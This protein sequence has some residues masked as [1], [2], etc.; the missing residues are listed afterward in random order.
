[1]AW[2]PDEHFEALIQKAIDFLQNVRIARHTVYREYAI[3][4]LQGNWG[5]YRI[6]IS[7]VHRGDKTVKYSYYLL[8]Q[9]NGLVIG[10]DNSADN[11]VLRLR[12]G[13]NWMSHLHEELPHQHTP[14][15]DIRLTEW[16]DFDGF[17]A[18]VE[19][20]L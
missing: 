17:I 3:L 1:M 11:L 20:N 12:Y 6:I 15:G 19:N 14:D 10:F 4:E 18:W 9:D 13:S 5:N 2:P 16:M 8:D 7:E